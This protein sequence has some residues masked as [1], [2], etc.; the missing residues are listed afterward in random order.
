MAMTL[1]NSGTQ[2]WAL[3]T[4]QHWEK[5]KVN[6]LTDIHLANAAQDPGTGPG[7]QDSGSENTDPALESSMALGEATYGTL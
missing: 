3:T 7:I 4:A 6:D 5:W 1:A 2:K